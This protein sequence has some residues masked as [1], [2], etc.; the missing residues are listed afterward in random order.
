MTT[1]A[2]LWGPRPAGCMGPA[3]AARGACLRRGRRR[4]L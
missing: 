3:A 4:V 1:S 2:G